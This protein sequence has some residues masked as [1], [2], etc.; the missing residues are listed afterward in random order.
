MLCTII[1]G[2]TFED[3]RNQLIQAQDGCS[4]V[5]LRLDFFKDLNLDQL[6]KLR[7]EFPIPMI[8]TFR[9]V[10]Q[11]GA[12]EGSEEER[13]EQ[14]KKLSTL[15]PEYIDLEY[16]VPS[17]FAKNLKA[18]N[19]ETKVIV[20]FHD[21]EKMPPLTPVLEKLKKLDADLYKI[22]VMIHSSA[23]ALS[24]LSFMKENQPNVVVMG[25]GPYGEI[26]RILSPIFGGRFVYASL[27][28]GLSTAPG[29]LTV[30]QL[31]T[32]YRY[33]NLR[34]STAIYGL[35]GDPV[36]K[37]I[38]SIV[39]NAIMHKFNLSSVYVNFPIA[40]EQ[41]AEFLNWAKKTGIAGLSVTTPLKEEIIPFL[42]EVDP[43]AEKEG[44]VN[45]LLFDKGRVKGFNTDEK[46]AID[47]LDRY[48]MYINQTVD[49]FKIWFGKRAPPT[50]IKPEIAK[51][52]LK[53]GY[54]PSV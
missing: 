5:E 49:Q 47:A 25:M 45:T 43:R 51:E 2:P 18:E 42:D 40:K 50:Q 37:S 54:T 9:P 36:D 32:I 12:F 46:G 27:N 10:S 33:N 22:A 11:G 48:E 13:L 16:N 4:L 52:L 21:F 23:E 19:P 53:N 44:V 26:T 15:K 30:K 34:P 7:Q 24:L 20:S 17:S 29:Q 3:A 39:H 6:K 8:F 35:I 28:Q 14:I 31:L 38:G 1:K 41:L